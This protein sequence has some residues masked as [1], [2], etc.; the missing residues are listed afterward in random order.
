VCPSPEFWAC[1]R[2]A[3]SGDEVKQKRGFATVD[4]RGLAIA[5]PVD[6]ALHGNQRFLV[7]NRR[8]VCR[9]A[10]PGLDCIESVDS[11][12]QRVA[13]LKRTYVD[14]DPADFLSGRRYA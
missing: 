5:T 1:N 4:T 7:V 12:P 14:V 13:N 9:F 8:G 3:D 6:L 11:R 10:L 2:V